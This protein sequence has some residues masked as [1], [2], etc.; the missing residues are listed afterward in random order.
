MP[1]LRTKIFRLWFRLSRPMTLGA[2]AIVENAD[3]EILLVRHTYA[4]GLFL[5]GGG[6]E[7]GE[8]VHQT[9]RK[10]LR[11]EAGLE[12]TEDARQVR[13]YS[14]HRI[15]HNDHVVLFRVSAGS[16]TQT[17]TPDA[18]EISELVWCH[19]LK[20]PADT[21]PATKRRLAEAFSGATVSDH[22]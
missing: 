13:I 6:V 19:P 17:G 8:T 12:L 4:K 3:G 10:E 2:R 18:R 5:P 22:W 21:T 7:T 9:I 14:N 15:M 11:E 1:N 16:W 20:P